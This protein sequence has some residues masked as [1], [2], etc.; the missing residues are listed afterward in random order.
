MLSLQPTN[1]TRVL[2]KDQDEYNA[3]AI[4]DVVTEDGGSYMVS[5]WEPTPKELAALNNGGYVRLIILGRVHPPVAIN[6][7]EN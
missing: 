7:Q 3:L 5:L 1:T 6:V 4:V 2:A